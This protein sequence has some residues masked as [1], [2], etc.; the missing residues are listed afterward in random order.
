MSYRLQLP[1]SARIHPVFH[2]SQL[3]KAIGNYSAE[4]TLPDGLEVRVEEVEPPEKL[5]AIR[6]IQLVGQHKRQWLVKWKSR[7]SDLTWEDDELLRSQFL[8]FSY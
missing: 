8:D 3:K 7:N 6:D 2:I 4:A 5:L 1:S